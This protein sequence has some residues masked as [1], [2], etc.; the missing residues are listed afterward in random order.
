M[1]GKS[2]KILG[3][4]INSIPKEKVL[5]QIHSKLNRNEK[6]YIV[7]P[8]PEQVLLAQKDIQFADILNSSDISLADGIGLVAAAKFFALPKPR[9]PV[10]K[11]LV[12]F[13]QGLGVGVSILLDRDWLKTELQLVKGRE[14]FIELIKLAGRKG[15]K[16]ILIGNRKRSAQKAARKLRNNFIKLDIVGITG[17]NLD[18]NAKTVSKEDALIEEKAIAKINREKPDL[19][20]IG[21]RAPVQ[22]KWLYRWYDKLDFKCAMVVGGTFDYISGAK[23][24]PPKWIE[25]LNLE[26]LWR[27]LKGDQKVRRIFRAF[28]EFALRIYWQKLIG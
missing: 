6:F 25:D 10:K 5:M 4:A 11:A 27:F 19:L 7:T 1:I 9:N 13:T 12:L 20:F 3:I 26:W 8:N 18:N 24:L 14:V 22:E 17:P 23:P 21:F 2:V 16:V 15:W 28:P